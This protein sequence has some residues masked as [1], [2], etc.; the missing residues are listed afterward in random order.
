MTITN[1]SDKDSIYIIIEND[2]TNSKIEVYI[3]DSDEI[4]TSKLTIN[5]DKSYVYIT[6]DGYTH[7]KTIVM[8][9]TKI[10]Y[11]TLTSII[12]NTIKALY[13]NEPLSANIYEMI[14]KLL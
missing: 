2:I 1:K 5:D 11:I 13:D 3:N 4:S 10:P 8:K 12:N 14:T 7:N 9:G 6:Y